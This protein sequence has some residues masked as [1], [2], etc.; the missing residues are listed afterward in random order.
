MPPN[1]HGCAKVYNVCVC[2]VGGGGGGGGGGYFLF[3][4]GIDGGGGVVNAVLRAL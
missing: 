3:T 4:C 2:V 1:A